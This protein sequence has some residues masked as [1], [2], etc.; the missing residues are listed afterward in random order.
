MQNR[1]REGGA[2]TLNAIAGIGM[3]AV[4]I[5]GFPFIGFLQDSSVS[6]SVENELPALY[7]QLTVERGYVLGDY[8]SLDAGAVAALPQEQQEAISG[9]AERESQGALARMIMFPVFMLVCYIGLI[10]YFKRQGGYKP[11]VLGE[12]AH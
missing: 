2:L 5:L 6:A 10:L 4:G 12:A 9:I 7:Q 11:K 8:R 3:L 1:P